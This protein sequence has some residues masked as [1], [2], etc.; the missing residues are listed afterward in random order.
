MTTPSSATETSNNPSQGTAATEFVSG[1][2]TPNHPQPVNPSGNLVPSKIDEPSPEAGN[3]PEQ[4]PVQDPAPSDPAQPKVDEVPHDKDDSGVVI[5]DETGDAGLDLA[6]SFIGSLGIAG[7]DPVM[8]AAANGDFSF[9]EAKLSTMGDEARG[10]EKHV[11]IGKDAFER[12][13]NSFKA[14]QEAT[15]KAV[16][17]IAGGEK[18]WKAI[19]E[20]AGKTADAAEKEALNQMFDAGGFQ[21]QAAARALVSAYQ[22]AQG[23]TITPANPAAT[24]SGVPAQAPTRLTQADYHNEVSKLFN[25]LGNAMDTSPEYAELKRRYFGR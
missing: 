6:L 14:E 18:N 1:S 19:V 13:L 17:A 21:A 16:H 10:W 9:L 24:A 22:S 23:T 2:L 20:W 5:Y 8:V 7:N 11:Q 25:R 15:N 4:P 3:Q 12:Q